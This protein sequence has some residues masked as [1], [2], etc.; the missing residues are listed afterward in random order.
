MLH[1]HLVGLLFFL[2]PEILF[3]NQV[4]FSNRCAFLLAAAGT[5]PPQGR[6][7]CPDCMRL[8]S[9]PAGCLWGREPPASLLVWGAGGCFYRTAWAPVPWVTSHRFGG[10]SAHPSAPGG[11]VG[12]LE[13]WA[14]P[15]SWHRAGDACRAARLPCSAVPGWEENVL[16]PGPHQDTHPGSFQTH[17]LGHSRIPTVTPYI[18]FRA[19]SRGGSDAS[20]E[21]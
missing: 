19:K 21:C 2:V 17:I 6:W 18:N 1:S 14:G 9:S 16:G 20:L 15:G 8:A 5:R 3:Q 13:S 10:G 11:K 12:W 7:L 4:V